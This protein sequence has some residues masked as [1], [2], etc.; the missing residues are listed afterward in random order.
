MA[1]TNTVR[2]A[3]ETMLVDRTDEQIDAHL[4]DLRAEAMYAAGSRGVKVMRELVCWMQVMGELK[5]VA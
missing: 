2:A 4:A 1:T 3:V 5:E